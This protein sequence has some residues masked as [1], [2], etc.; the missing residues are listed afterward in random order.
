MKKRIRS[1]LRNP[2]VIVLPLVAASWFGWTQ[3]MRAINMPDH[4]E[5]NL[6][7]NGGFEEVG[8]GNV[9]S[10]WKLKA[11]D[12]VSYFPQKVRGFGG[13]TALG[14]TVSRYNGGGLEV[15]SPIVS[16]QPNQT[17]FFKGYHKASAPFWLLIRYFNKNG[18]STLKLVQQYGPTGQWT[19][20]SA[21]FKTDA[22]ASRMQVVYMI[23]SKGSVSLDRIFVDKRSQGIQLA[24]VQPSSEEKNLLA[25]GDVSEGTVAS[26][27]D[28]L[29][30]SKGNNSADFSYIKRDGE[31]YIRTQ[32][33]NYQDGEAK[34]V[35]PTIKAEA[36]QYVRFSSDYRSNV[37]A[38]VVAEYVLDD[39]TRSFVT[40]AKLPPASTWTSFD[41]FS[42]APFEATALTINVVLSGNGTLDT[43]NY[44]IQD[45]TQP[46][47]RHFKQPMV[48]LT[49]DEGWES[50]YATA[51]RIM[52]YLGFK[53][54]FYINPAAVEEEAFMTGDQLNKLLKEGHQIAAESNEYVD[55]TTLNSRQLKRQ[56]QL[57]HDYLTMQLHLI[58]VDFAPTGG[59][60]DP[61]IQSMA[62][63]YFRSSRGNSEGLNT[64]Q[65]FD[66]YN[67]K[68]FY[69]DSNTTP[70]RLQHALDEAEQKNGWLILVYHRVEDDFKSKTT[71]GSKAFAD[72]MEQIHK[73]G[74]QVETVENGLNEAWS[75]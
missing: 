30:F 23:S 70:E 46:G 44:L 34:W 42:E 54:T 62:K 6:L 58:N 50:G 15:Q 18:G 7:Q 61:A 49:F 69:V 27:T 68:T 9:P 5:Y 71:V 4:A 32:V 73:S 67:L 16:V 1:T 22:Q 51:A 65:N 47:T 39:G 64:K 21:A 48:S 59:H 31:S 37:P 36:G 38:S 24:S 45:V 55:L 8:A 3:Y 12:S 66:A 11:T 13:G 75:D 20:N 52:S 57:S 43:D 35:P 29:P 25:N 28:W 17:Y 10:G 33:S 63:L 2:L 56:L 72:Q 40:L 19:S 41:V 53:G 26:P 60:D 14:V 74:I